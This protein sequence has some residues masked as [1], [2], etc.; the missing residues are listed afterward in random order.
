MKVSVYL[1][2]KFRAFGITF[3]Q[4]ERKWDHTIKL[5]DENGAIAIITQGIPTTVVDLDQNGI[6]L[7]V[8]VA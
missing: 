6:R 4:F 5:R 1:K 3:K 7:L 8:A 2:V